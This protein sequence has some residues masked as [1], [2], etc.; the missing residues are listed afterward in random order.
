MKTSTFALA[1]A[2]AAL[3]LLAQDKTLNCNNRDYN[4]RKQVTHCEMREQTVG[5]AGR[6]SID[7]GTN[8]GV[9][10]KA[11]DGGSV[12]VR[13]KVEASGDD[14]GAAAGVT[15]QIRVDVSAGQV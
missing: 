11:W 15:S 5:Y 6:L 10:V 1:I 14:E 13:S 12:L 3:P 2:L 9:S 8:G 7:A 4:Q